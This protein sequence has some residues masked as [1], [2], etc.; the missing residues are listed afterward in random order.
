VHE[1]AGAKVVL[2][3]AAL[4]K[5]GG[6][7][8]RGTG[9]TDEGGLPEFRDRQRHRL[10]NGGEDLGIHRTECCDIR[11]G[12][13]RPLKYRATS[14]HD[15]HG[16]TSELHGDDDVAE[17]DRRIDVVPAHRLEGDLACDFWREAR[18]EH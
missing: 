9:E 12:A 3:R 4:D 1:G 16:D 10:A 17:E 2:R 11:C 6:E 5:V 18:L 14:G 13:N 7:R 15:L 8:E